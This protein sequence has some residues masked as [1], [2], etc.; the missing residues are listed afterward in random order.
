MVKI[1]WKEIPPSINKLYYFRKGRRILSSE[2]RA[3]KNR[4]ISGRGGLSF[5]DLTSIDISKEERLSLTLRFYL[6]ED[7][8]F[9]KN[10]GKDKRVKS[11][12]K[13]LDVSNLIKITE[14]ALS[15]LLCIDDRANFEIHAYKDV[16]NTDEMIEIILSAIG[17]HNE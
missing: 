4:F 12:F 17:E 11:P 5:N 14:D 1:V 16:C 6:K 3:W 10:W 9:S 8:V 13:R 7:R 15:E 2:G